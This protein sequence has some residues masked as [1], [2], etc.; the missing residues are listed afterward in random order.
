MIAAI[1]LLLPWKIRSELVAMK[2]AGK[3]DLEIAEFT[4]VPEK[5]VNVVIRSNYGVLSSR[6]N[7]ELDGG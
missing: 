7:K 6:V 2:E 5:F 4:K 3:T 1:E